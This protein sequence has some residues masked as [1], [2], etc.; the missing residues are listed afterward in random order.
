MKFSLIVAAAMLAL[1]QAAPSLDGIQLHLKQ[2]GDKMVEALTEITQN[3]NLTDQAYTLGQGSK[4]QLE[5]VVTKIEEQLRTVATH[6]KEQIQPLA[7]NLQTDIESHM[8]N[9]QR[10]MEAIIQ[11]LTGLTKATDD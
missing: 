3:N 2:I 7:A 11:Q 8:G 5:P 10:Q 9:F 6:M 4:T 1:A